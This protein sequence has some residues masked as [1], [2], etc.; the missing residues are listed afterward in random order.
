MRITLVQLTII[1]TLF[2]S[3][4]AKSSKAQ[5]ALETRVSVSETNQSLKNVLRTLEGRT[6]V[7]FTY[8]AELIN[9]DQ[10]VSLIVNSRK[11]GDVLNL[12]LSPL[13]L[14]YDVSGDVIVIRVNKGPH[15][16][17][18][19]VSHGEIDMSRAPIKGKVVD[20]AGL[21]LPG[22]S[23]KVKGTQTGTV[24]DANGDFNLNVAAGT[25]LVVSYIGFET[26]EMTAGNDPLKIKMVASS[27]SLN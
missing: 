24:T 10:K 9:A 8:V 25:V 17:P 16:V 23:I 4:F 22:V 7:S 27:S 19:P 21:P 1:L 26:Q 12:L 2:G 18:E 11:L 14:S 3:A 5:A 20:E 13:N 6:N 15:Q